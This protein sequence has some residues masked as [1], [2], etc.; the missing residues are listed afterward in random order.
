MNQK[1]LILTI[2]NLSYF[3]KEVV[4]EVLES[5]GQV[6]AETL[7]SGEES[8]LFPQ[9]GTYKPQRREQRRRVLPNGQECLVVSKRIG[10]F[11]PGQAFRQRV[12]GER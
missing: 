2:A 8:V 3:P 4:R 11:V 5:A 9:L 12:N 1:E 10:K 7:A 6:I